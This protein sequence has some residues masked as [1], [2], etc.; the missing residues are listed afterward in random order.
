MPSAL[1]RTTIRATVAALAMC[2]A[3]SCA[4][5][6]APA[7]PTT[8]KPPG[9]AL[10]A[11]T[12]TSTTTST[13][14]TTTTTTT[15]PLA[16]PVPGFV[17]SAIAPRLSYTVSHEGLPAE[18]LG[19]LEEAARTASEISGI[20][21]E[22]STAPSTGAA[23]AQGEIRVR[24][25]NLCSSD[26]AVGCAVVY[27]TSTHIVATDM[28]VA[29][30]MLGDARLLSVVLHELGHAIG[31]QHVDTAGFKPQVMGNNGEPLQAYPAGDR[32]G[33]VAAG[34]D[35]VAASSSIAVASVDEPQVIGR[36]EAT[37]D[38]GDHPQH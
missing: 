36:Y 22:M 32:A 20:T 25:G 38:G 30:S 33:L 27:G 24:M 14:T 37:L 13:T 3:A 9:P 2:V 17:R 1:R 21:L 34:A 11:T 12:T 10:R 26:H 29:A 8:T 7:A 6:P 35:A 23:P 16:D 19:A 31:L 15:A 5:P 4:P 28:S 18:V